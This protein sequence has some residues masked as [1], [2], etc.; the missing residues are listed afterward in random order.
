MGVAF[1]APANLDLLQRAL[2]N[3]ERASLTLIDTPGLSAN[4]GDSNAALG[5]FLAK[6]A[7]IDV[8]LVLPAFAGWE[9]L[10]NGCSMQVIPS[11]QASVHGTG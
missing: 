8:H 3:E 7:D 2:Q 6:R 9:E 1:E 4:N 5:S 11:L 10:R